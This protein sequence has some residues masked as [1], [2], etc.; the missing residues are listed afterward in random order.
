[1]NKS[2][3]K[4]W[5]ENPWRIVNS[6]ARRGWLS[7]L[8]DKA[9]ISLIYRAAFGKKLNWRTPKTFNEKLQWLKIYDRNPVYNMMVD[10]YEAKK[11]AADKIE[12][13]YIVPALGGP[14][15][16]FD[17][18]DFDNLP[19]Q[20][21]LKT[22][23]DCG[24]VVICKDKVSFDMLAARNFIEH[25]L[26]R[27]YYLSCREW[28]Y[29]YVKPRIFAEKYLSDVELGD[30]RD[31]KFFCFDGVPKLMFIASERQSKDQETKFDFYDMD[32][33]HLP[34]INGHPN[35]ENYIACPVNF[36]KMK[37]LASKLS[38][39]VPHLRVDFYESN[40]NLYLGELTFSH[41]GGLVPFEPEEWDEIIGSWLK[42]PIRD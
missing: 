12:H 32:F 5:Q 13:K 8:S 37:E 7:C 38:V 40:G 21:V 11:Y 28:P 23:H 1:M 29:K 36:E 19:E 31:Y 3:I 18:I 4:R 42:L 35:S 26:K 2:T 17:E 41:W 27:N 6:L 25:H 30:L 20:F 22:T 34:I 33:N 24:G 16:N 9:Y 14:W 39:G 10:K 15:E